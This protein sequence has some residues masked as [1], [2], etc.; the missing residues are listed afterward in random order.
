MERELWREG[1]G[2]RKRFRH[3]VIVKSL[4]WGLQEHTIAPDV[5]AYRLLRRAVEHLQEMTCREAQLKASTQDMRDPVTK[6]MEMAMIRYS[7]HVKRMKVRPKPDWR[8]REI[9]VCNLL[10]FKTSGCWRLFFEFLPVG[11]GGQFFN[12]R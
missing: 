12:N 2:H 10:V 11:G 1:P 8:V 5:M 4:W 7:P 3:M 9:K 6:R